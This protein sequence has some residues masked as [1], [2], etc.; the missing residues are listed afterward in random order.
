VRQA[1]GKYTTFTVGGINILNTQA[2]KFGY[3]GGP[4]RYQAENKFYSDP[5]FAD[6]AY[7]QGLPENIGESFGIPPAQITLSVGI[8][9]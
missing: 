5:S 4:G 9:L 8:K 2:G 1:F 7:N 6:E 3:I